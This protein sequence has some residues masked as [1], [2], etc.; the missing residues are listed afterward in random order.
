VL[1]SSLISRVFFLM[2][3]SAELGNEGGVVFGY[4]LA[5]YGEALRSSNTCRLEDRPVLVVTVEG[6]VQECKSLLSK[7]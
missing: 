7:N 5:G 3:G 4:M 6:V 2:V 1:R